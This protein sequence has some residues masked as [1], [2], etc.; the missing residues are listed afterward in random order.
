MPFV[1]QD[2]LSARESLERYREKAVSAHH[3]RFSFPFFCGTYF[4]YR[5]A[6]V[7]RVAAIAKAVSDDP[8]YLDV[9]CGYGDFLGKVREYLPRARGLEIDS[10]IF[11]GLGAAK[12]EYI[13]TGDARWLASDG[14]KYDAVFV[15]WMEPGQDYRDAVSKITDVII[16]TLDQGISLAAEFDGHG[17]ERVAWWR[18]PSWEDVNT[19]LMNSYYTREL[20]EDRSKRAQLHSQRGAHNL[21]YVYSRPALRQKIVSALQEQLRIEAA[22]PTGGYEFEEVLDECGFSYGERLKGGEELW[23]IFFG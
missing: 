7:R 8:S 9:G 12:P 10:S 14:R 18:T 4:A 22:G 13:D 1:L 16:T 21:W 15:G 3:E 5:R 23:K 19:E 6:D 2:L 17:F 20:A 11:Y